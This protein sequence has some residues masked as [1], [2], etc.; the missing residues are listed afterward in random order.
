MCLTSDLRGVLDQFFPFIPGANP[1]DPARAG[2]AGPARSG[3][4]STI[5]R[6]LEFS[7]PN[8]SGSAPISGGHNTHQKGFNVL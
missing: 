6:N 4:F 2:P 7:G 3:T 1:S 5:S 8:R